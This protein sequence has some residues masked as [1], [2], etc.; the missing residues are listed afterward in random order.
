MNKEII[1][2]ISSVI[3]VL[4]NTEVK[5]KNNLLNLG[6]SIAILEEVRHDCIISLKEN[7]DKI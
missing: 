3:E 7:T 2:K 4:G 6:G 1:E 5:G